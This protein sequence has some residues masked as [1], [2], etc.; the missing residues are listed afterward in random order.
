MKREVNIINNKVLIILTV[1]VAL[2][3]VFQVFGA[4]LTGGAILKKESTVTYNNVLNMISNCKSVSLYERAGGFS[5]GK[6]LA[7]G[8]TPQQY[9]KKKGYDSCLLVNNEFFERYYD[10]SDGSCDGDMNFENWRTSINSPADC[11][12]LLSKDFLTFMGFP[13]GESVGCKSGGIANTD[14]MNTYDPEVICC[15]IPKN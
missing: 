2:V 5:A 3:F 13:Y 8:F 9:C 4:N 7:E 1:L 10:S 6:F 11:S 12:T 15:S 14:F